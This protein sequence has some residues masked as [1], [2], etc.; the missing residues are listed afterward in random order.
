MRRRS[1]IQDAGD[2][3]DVVARI[4]C[5]LGGCDE[6][7]EVDH[8]LEIR[9]ARLGE[10]S[11]Q[12][13][14]TQSDGTCQLL[15][16]HRPT[17]VR[18]DYIPRGTLQ[19]RRQA[20][21]LRRLCESLTKAG[22]ESVRMN[23][24]AR[25]VLIDSLDQEI[26]EAQAGAPCRGRRV[27]SAQRHDGEERRTR[28]LGGKCRCFPRV[29]IRSTHVDDGGVDEHPSKDCF[30]LF[31]R[32]GRDDPPSPPWE[33]RSHHRA[34][35]LSLEMNDKR[36]QRRAICRGS[37][38]D[39]GLYGVEVWL[40]LNELANNRVLGVLDLVDGT[41]LAAFSVVKHGDA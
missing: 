29:F 23:Q 3:A 16:R 12:V 31:G 11:A 36:G 35:P 1:E 13:L 9:C 25:C 41:H 6:T 32:A 19:L 26:D 5:E 27:R 4:L 39:A 14:A 22:G 10:V 18:H 8:A 7:N 24:V 20:K 40:P 2:V 34:R 17:R 33:R 28:E 37:Q 15:R 21:R 38:S 30:Q